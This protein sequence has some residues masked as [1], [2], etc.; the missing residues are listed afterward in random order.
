MGIDD[1]DKIERKLATTVSPGAYSASYP[2]DAQ[3]ADVVIHDMTSLMVS[4]TMSLKA[5]TLE[6]LA[7][8]TRWPISDLYTG[9]I[10][11]AERVKLIYALDDS[12]FLPKL[13]EMQHE[14]RYAS[15]KPL[16][17]DEIGDLR[18]EGDQLLPGSRDGEDMSHRKRAFYNPHASFLWNAYVRWSLVTKI[19]AGVD[20]TRR[21]DACQPFKNTA[22][23]ALWDG[24]LCYTRPENPGESPV[25]CVCDDDLRGPTLTVE[26]V[27]CGFG[28]SDRA[29]G[30]LYR[31]IGP[32]AVRRIKRM[33]RIVTVDLKCR[34]VLK[35]SKRPLRIGE[36]DLKMVH[37]V[38]RETPVH[39]TALVRNNDSDVMWILLLNMPR[40][41]NRTIILDR[42]SPNMKES[43]RPFRF[44]NIN[45]LYA[46]LAC[47]FFRGGLNR[48]PFVVTEMHHSVVLAAFVAITMGSDYTSRPAKLHTTGIVEA[49]FGEHESVEPSA[50]PAGTAG[51]IVVKHCGGACSRLITMD[52]DF[53]DMR[54]VVAAMYMRMANS[55]IRKR[56]LT[57]WSACTPGKH[58]F[59]DVVYRLTQ[60]AARPMPSFPEVDAHCRRVLWTINYMTNGMLGMGAIPSPFG[61]E[62][63]S[64]GLWGWALV[65]PEFVEGSG[66]AR[67]VKPDAD[68]DKVIRKRPR[69]DGIVVPVNIPTQRHTHESAMEMHGVIYVEYNTKRRKIRESVANRH[70]DDADAA[71]QWQTHT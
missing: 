70:Y 13:R 44:I 33:Q 2:E 68:M 22:A 71:A 3:S 10:R 1:H 51:P 45:K 52:Y 23:N 40:I 69:S 17:A 39:G 32:D 37:Y 31:D 28:T 7:E 12:R 25:G 49:M 15:A 36:S 34:A 30:K 57:E 16:S 27:P 38:M 55:P 65:D 4:A 19:L 56:I 8:R 48:T 41:Y 24:T 43:R 35:A 20:F 54:D 46:S 59:A 21:C 50:W 64:P 47:H 42:G 53:V 18:M 9:N 58:H 62:R 66:M 63:S 11:C 26:N 14:K 5:S 29:L 67:K 61:V 6:D 60:K